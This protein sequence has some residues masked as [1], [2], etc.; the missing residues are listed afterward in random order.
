MISSRALGFVPYSTNR[1]LRDTKSIHEAPLSLREGKNLKA[2]KIRQG[3]KFIPLRELSSSSSDSGSSNGICSAINP[4]TAQ[5][6]SLSWQGAYRTP[7]I[8]G[9]AAS[10]ARHNINQWKAEQTAARRA[11]VLQVFI[12]GARVPLAREGGANI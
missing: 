5:G 2:K 11:K 4:L 3:F 7:S 6:R 9:A 12:A 8:R 10:D 1:G